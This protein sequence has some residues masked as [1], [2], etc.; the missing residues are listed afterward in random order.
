MGIRFE[1]YE[2]PYVVAGT[3][4][5]LY[6]LNAQ[7]CTC[8]LCIPIN[9]WPSVNYTCFQQRIYQV[10]F[11]FLMTNFALALLL[12]S[13]DLEVV[14]YEGAVREKPSSKEEARQFLRG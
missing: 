4:H 2:C 5:E 6:P 1:E 13:N 11:L 8:M 7:M 10:S 9:K 12:L 3:L 14:V